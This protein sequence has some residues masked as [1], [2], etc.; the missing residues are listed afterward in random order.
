MS[1]LHGPVP[2]PAHGSWPSTSAPDPVTGLV[3]FPE[4]A[5]CL[6]AFLTDQARLGQPVGIA[7]GDVDHLKSYV[8][9]TN[10]TQPASFGHLAGNAYMAAL[11]RICSSW[12]HASRFPAGCVSTFGG[13][14][15]II[16]A[17]VA[18]RRAFAAAVS[19]LRDHCRRQLPRSVSFATT[20][21]TPQPDQN[22]NADGVLSAVDAALFRRKSARTGGRIRPVRHQ[23]TQPPERCFRLRHRVA[24]SRRCVARQ[25]PVV[26]C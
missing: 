18:G 21:I 26:L 23:H 24:V 12:F 25:L 22:W 17:T 5:T 1:H 6:A 2:F 15:V 14:E 9:D 11:G 10:S 8:E 3:G 4:F 19:T 7:I 16:T 20:V 13:D